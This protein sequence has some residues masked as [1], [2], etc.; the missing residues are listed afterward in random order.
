MNRM[1]NRDVSERTFT[2]NFFTKIA[3]ISMMFSLISCSTNEVDNAQLGK[4]RHLLAELE[5]NQLLWSES[6]VT[7][8]S[9][10]LN[11]ECADCPTEE[12]ADQSIIVKSGNVANTGV[13]S[14]KSGVGA[15]SITARD[16]D[17]DD[18]RRFTQGIQSVRVES[19][20]T[21]LRQAILQNSVQ[22]VRFDPIYGYP[23]TVQINNA[24]LRALDFDDDDDNFRNVVPN[25]SFNTSG[26]QVFGTNNV[27]QTITLS[28]QLIRQGN[29][30]WLIDNNGQ[31]KQLN[32]SGN[33]YSS[34]NSIPNQSYVQVTGQW[35]PGGVSGQGQVNVLSISS[36]QT[37]QFQ[38]NLAG[39]LLYSVLDDD[40]Y[41]LDDFFVTNDRGNRVFLNLPANLQSQAF[42]L[43]GQRVNLNGNWTPFFNA[44][45]ARFNP[46]GLTSPNTV[47]NTFTG[48][49]T[50]GSTYQ[51]PGL[52]Q[53]NY[54]LIDDFGAVRE[55]QVPANL[56]YSL[57]MSLGQRVTLQGTER[58]S[59]VYGQSVIYVQSVNQL[60]NVFTNTLISGT[61]TAVLPADIFG[62]SESV[63]LQ[64]DTG[65]T[66]TLQIPSIYRDPYNSLLIGMR[67]QANGVWIS[68]ASFGQGQFEAR[69]PIQITN[70]GF[71]TTST[72]SGYVSNVGSFSNGTNCNATQTNYTFT[73]DTGQ[74]F[75]LYVSNTTLINGLNTQGTNLPFQ[76]RIQVT[77][78]QVSPGVLQAQTINVTPQFETSI[79]GTIIE[80]GAAGSTF[81][82]T[83]TLNTYRLLDTFG[84]AYS[85]T[86]TRNSIIQGNQGSFL[87]I[88]DTV[89]VTGTMSNNGATFNASRVIATSAAYSPIPGLPP[90]Q[91]PLP[92]NNT[93]VFTGIVTGLDCSLNG[94]DTYNFVDQSGK[95]YALSISQFVSP[96]IFIDVG[97]SL[98]VTGSLIN[99]KIDAQSVIQ[100][101][102][103]ANPINRVLESGSIIAVTGS[104]PTSCNTPVYT[105]QFQ[106]DNGQISQ[107]R[108]T[109]EAAQHL[110]QPFSIGSRLTITA[111]LQSNNPQLIDVIEISLNGSGVQAGQPFG[112]VNNGGFNNG[113]F[114]TGGQTI[115]VLGTIVSTACSNEYYFVDQNGR[116]YQLQLSQTNFNIPTNV[117]AKLNVT[118]QI[119]GNK[120]IAN[121]V[122]SDTTGVFAPVP[123]PVSGTINSIISTETLSC[124]V[125]VTTY[126]FQNANGR[127][128][129]LRVS[130]SNVNFGST[131]QTLPVG[132]RVTI[133]NKIESFDG[134]VIDALNISQNNFF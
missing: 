100:L 47:L 67:I 63:L 92:I 116:G 109:T 5:R 9:F 104:L 22:Q 96:G 70:L 127:S 114:N 7:D 76:S 20:F 28:G 119:V 37:N 10:S 120:L 123:M 42:Q 48:I 105:Y 71:T 1:I 131:G 12:S 107:I 93:T 110:P 41:D 83:G 133:T 75:Q 130:S 8:Y 68:N 13:V 91:A 51:I 115:S 84:N 58:F 19:L 99:N 74:I 18:D 31:I 111:K 103:F 33:V 35:L 65:S 85:I 45:N 122:Y 56:T 124:G 43:A 69:A 38:S 102:T 97:T 77:G 21:D 81:T 82:C 128:Q 73:T 80:I 108:L 64:L 78:I 60:Q 117:G 34:I 112:G 126:Q 88:G 129:R 11:K 89:Q 61:I 72:Y 16:D 54:I 23:Q 26:F 32:V 3:I 113:G 46:S 86:T 87:R 57:S 6:G 29:T 24:N 53:S 14:S 118:G 2:T 30:F 95:L 25:V 90:F 132:S 27:A 79:S 52:Q 44:P 101:Q 59:G 106:N 4:Q 15:R 17:D 50:Q 66:V 62:A 134:S 40:S 121:N 55:L 125:T 36:T 49:L 94:T 98:Q 39:T